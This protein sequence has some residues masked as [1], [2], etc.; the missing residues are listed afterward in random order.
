[1]FTD[2]VSALAEI[3]GSYPKN[4]LFIRNKSVHLQDRSV[5]EMCYL[6]LKTKLVC[7]ECRVMCLKYLVLANM[8]M[9][10][11]VDPFDAQEAKPYRND[12]QIQVMTDLVTASQNNDINKFE[13][14][15][16]SNR[17]AIMDDPFIR[18]YIE[19]LMTGIRTQ[20]RDLRTS[21]ES[22]VFWQNRTEQ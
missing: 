9:E 20:V 10:S 7:T 1:M 22:G 12:P 15:L 21:P 2:G 16:Q 8:L 3:S 18:N 6:V 4:H 17:K 13:R 14:V 11:K 19:D 5:P